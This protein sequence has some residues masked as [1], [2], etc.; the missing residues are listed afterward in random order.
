M[1]LIHPGQA[2]GNP[3][4]L[5]AAVN[6]PL[7]HLI[8]GP[9]LLV[10]ASRTRLGIFLGSRPVIYLEST[11]IGV[12]LTTLPAGG[13]ALVL[14]GSAT[15]MLSATLS[16]VALRD[17]DFGS[18]CRHWAASL[19]SCASGTTAGA[20]V[21][22]GITAVTGLPAGHAITSTSSTLIASLPVLAN[23]EWVFRDMGGQAAAAPQVP[24]ARGRMS[25]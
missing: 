4:G 7:A 22:Y 25:G 23:E 24:M 16:T 6:L 21:S 1:H 14:V 2:M 20:L 12:G 18:V 19:L 15:A 10:R 13:L 3:H 17:R 8:P 9:D 11:L 5:A